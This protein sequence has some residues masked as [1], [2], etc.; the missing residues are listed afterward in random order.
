L[1]N[2]RSV[3]ATVAGWTCTDP[4]LSPAPIG[5]DSIALSMG[6]LRA[7]AEQVSSIQ[8]PSLRVWQGQ[9]V[10]QRA[11]DESVG[12]PCCLSWLIVRLWTA[13]N[14]SCSATR[15]RR[16]QTGRMVPPDAGPS[17][18]FAFSNTACAW[19]PR[20]ALRRRSAAVFARA[21]H[22]E[23]NSTNIWRITLSELDLAG[24][25]APRLRGR[26]RIRRAGWSL[27]LGND[28]TGPRDF[29]C[30]RGALTAR[31]ALSL[32]TFCAEARCRSGKALGSA[33]ASNVAGPM[34]RGLSLFPFLTPW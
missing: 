34:I 25:R 31:P 28:C 26:A 14:V 21:R 3:H 22:L 32:C 11:T 33:M 24:G 4:P 18:Q 9:L 29:D 30:Q 7:N 8:C 13:I 5:W 20:R 15:R 6:P 10:R 19:M 12:W 17:A 16:L 23:A 2:D 1:R 27:I